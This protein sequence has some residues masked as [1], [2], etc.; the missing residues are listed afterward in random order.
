[1][2]H[3]RTL[4]EK[5]SLEGIHYSN[6]TVGFL[7]EKKPYDLIKVYYTYEKINFNQDVIEKLKEKFPLFIQIQKP[8][9]LKDFRDYIFHTNLD[10]YSYEQL[11]KILIAKKMNNQKID[12]TFLILYDKRKKEHI[13]SKNDKNEGIYTK[14]SL[15]F[16]NRKYR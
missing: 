12:D 14:S 3:L 5:S 8:G 7:L 16:Q 1:M 2:V 6:Q 13:I 11:K 10:N 15:R 9:T 4:T